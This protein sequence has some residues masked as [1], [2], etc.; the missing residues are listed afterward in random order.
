MI[1]SLYSAIS[2]LNSNNKAMSTI[3]DN[4][5]NSSTYGFKSSST[6]FA[7]MLNESLGAGGG[8]T[9]GAG[10]KVAGLSESWTQGSL[11]PTGNSTDLAI[12][13]SG[14]FQV[15]DGGVAGTDFYF[16]RVGAF[17]FD[18]DGYLTNSEKLLVQ[19]YN[20]SGGAVA[21]PPPAAPIN[22]Q[23]DSTT[24]RNVSIADGGIITGVN[25]A[26][27]TTEE[28]F[29]VSLFNF[30]N[31]QGLTKMGDGL[32][33]QSTESGAPV[34]ATGGVSGVAGLGTVLSGN[35][36]MSNVDLATEFSRM[37]VV[38]KAFQ[39]NAKVITTSDEILTSLINA[40]R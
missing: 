28:L 14:F 10:V 22:I 1:G 19:G 31:L 29:Q 5:A 13:G 9:P 6:L 7:N 16:T 37:I 18:A 30:N 20:V 39:A 25:I 24:H 23:V 15:R 8:D 26:K 12:S 11:E 21:D 35:L 33:C 34:S 38:Q 27:G 17:R 40:K 3:G 32:Y 36:E 4:I 2:G